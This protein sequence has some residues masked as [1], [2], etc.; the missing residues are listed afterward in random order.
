MKIDQ[1]RHNKAAGKSAS[2]FYKTFRSFF[3]D[4]LRKTGEMNKAKKRAFTEDEKM[5]YTLENTIVYIVL[6]DIDA[7][8]P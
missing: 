4:N 1:L 3:V 6:K 8:L 5:S 2:A 7:R